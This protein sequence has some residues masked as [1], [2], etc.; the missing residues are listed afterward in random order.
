MSRVEGVYSCGN[1]MHV[2]D[3]ADY[4]SESGEIAGK[5]PPPK[6]SQTP[7]KSS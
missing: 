7:I 6:T 5:A 4:V 1:A 3:L 2:N